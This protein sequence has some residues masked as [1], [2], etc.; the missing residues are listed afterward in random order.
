MGLCALLLVGSAE[1][2]IVEGSRVYKP[3]ILSIIQ[4]QSRN[5]GTI[6]RESDGIYLKLGPDYL[7]KIAA[8]L[9]DYT[10]NKDANIKIFDNKESANLQ[11]IAE[12]GNKSKIT[13][14]SFY[15]MVVDE[16]EYFML[17]VDAPELSALRQK[18][19]HAPQ[20]EDQAFNLVIGQ[21]KLES[22]DELA[23]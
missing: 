7:S 6:E 19:G 13:P 10:L 20:P 11:A 14:L 23:N 17:A 21:R 15:K 3:R 12:L 4:E 2:Y 8:F 16:I 5:V 9:P 1:S 22:H 18:Y